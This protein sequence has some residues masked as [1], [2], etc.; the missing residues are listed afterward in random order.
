MSEFLLIGKRLIPRGQIAIVESFVRGASP[1]L[2]TTRELRSRVVMI[3]RDSILTEQ[4]PDAF[5][6]EHGFRMLADELVANNPAI[7][8][9]V[10][11]V[12]PAEGFHPRKSYITRLLWRDVDGNHQSKLLATA[13][14]AGAS[15]AP[16]FGHAVDQ[17]AG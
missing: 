12:T 1:N 2:Q 14:E 3:N 6:A 7:R 11:A 9:R 10:E 17:A 13:L 15:F 16:V 5:A 8:F 4:T